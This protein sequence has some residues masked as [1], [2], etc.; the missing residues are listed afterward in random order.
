MLRS[1]G[2]QGPSGSTPYKEVFLRTNYLNIIEYG[3]STLTT[4][5][6]TAVTVSTGV[7]R[8]NIQNTA[9]RPANVYKIE[10]NADVIGGYGVNDDIYRVAV[11]ASATSSTG[12]I[13]FYIYKF[14]VVTHEF[15]AAAPVSGWHPVHI[16]IYS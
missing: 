3:Y 12:I 11:D 1:Q 5:N 16:R 14:N 10:V 9:D 7:Y 15:V 13:T 2:P 8:I 6:L 4:N